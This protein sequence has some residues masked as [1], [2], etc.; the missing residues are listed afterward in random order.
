MNEIRQEYIVV[1]YNPEF[2]C[3]SG[4]THRYVFDT[5]MNYFSEYDLDI[6]H[7]IEPKFIATS[8]P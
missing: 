5:W 2:Q 6:L 1:E 8:V 3:R 7:L 4:K